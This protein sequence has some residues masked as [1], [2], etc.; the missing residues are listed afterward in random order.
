MAHVPRGGH[1]RG[2]SS[3]SQADGARD[4]KIIEVPEQSRILSLPSLALRSPKLALFF[5]N[6]SENAHVRTVFHGRQVKSACHD[7]VIRIFDTF[8][9]A[10]IFRAN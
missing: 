6:V 1:E 4:L 2:G 10:Q 7:F 9:N 5:L 8:G 3:F